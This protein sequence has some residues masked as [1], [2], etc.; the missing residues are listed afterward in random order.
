MSEYY[1][2]CN[3]WFIFRLE[4]CAFEMRWGWG[5][6]CNIFPPQK[7]NIATGVWRWLEI[8]HLSLAKNNKS[9]QINHAV[10]VP[11]S[12]LRVLRSGRGGWSG[13]QWQ[14]EKHLRPDE[15][16]LARSNSVAAEDGDSRRPRATQ[17]FTV[18]GGKKYSSNCCDQRCT[19]KW[20][21]FLLFIG[22]KTK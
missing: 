12:G 8:K 13:S 16:H 10:G 7:S 11:T 4:V 19:N 14:V 21:L 20:K 6:V 5:L 18:A 2:W 3:L 9:K 17:G 15:G 1:V 22:N